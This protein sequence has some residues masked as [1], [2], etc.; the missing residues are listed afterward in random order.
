M[1]DMSVNI[2]ILN[3][4]Q[5]SAFNTIEHTHS[6]VLI[7]GQAGTGKSTFINYVKAVSNKRVICACPTAVSALNVSGQTIHS[8]FQIQPRDFIMP[9]LLKLKAKPRNIL[10]AADVLI[11]DEISMVAPDLLDAIDILARLARHN[12]DPFGGLQI[13]AIGDLFQLP[14]VITNDAKDYYVQTYEHAN[15]YF[16]DS[17]V[18]KRAQ[19]LRYDFNFVYRQSDKKLLE[20]L[21]RLRRNDLSAL[22]F[23]N[24]CKIDDVFKRENAVII[25]PF[26][27]VAEKINFDKLAQIESTEIS[28]TGELTGTFQER[29]VPA[30]LNLTLKVGALV[31]FVKNGDKWYNGS[32]GIVRNLNAREI[33][34]ELLN[35]KHDIVNVKP[36]KWSKIEYVRDENDRLIENEVGSFK[37]FP[38][39]LGY[40]MTIHKAQG[41]TLDAVTVDIS[42]GAFTHGQTYVA[43]SR[44]RKSSDIH[45]LTPLKPQDVIFDNRVLEFVDLNLFA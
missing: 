26:R 3:D 22:D 35:L 13:V 42:R 41:K 6:N 9:E 18:Y 28:Y 24:C 23:F 5:M 11:I 4:I 21:K 36:E 8:L 32:M 7:L 43:L 34:V 25:T 31:V 15:A 37:Q 19:F 20:N 39:N 30:P 44:T 1:N 33:Q 27:S 38:L 45:V 10:N 12:N 40:A 16:F 29:D 2:P 14:P 17:N